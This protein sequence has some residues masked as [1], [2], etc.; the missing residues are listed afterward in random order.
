MHARRHK[1]IAKDEIAALSRDSLR[2]VLDTSST[3][4]FNESYSLWHF[5]PKEMY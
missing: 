3:L 4:P 2:D 1:G 5:Q